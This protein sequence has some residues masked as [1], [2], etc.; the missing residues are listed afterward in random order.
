MSLRVVFFGTPEMA[1]AALTAVVRAGHRVLAGVCQPDRPA[2]RGRKLKPPQVK[3]ECGLLGVP[4]LQPE[5]I[6][7]SGFK[8]ELATLKPDVLVVVAYG[9]ILDREILDIPRIMPVNLHF[10]LLPQLRGA[11]PHNWALIQGLAETGVTTIRMVS[12][13]DAGPILLQRRTLIEPRETAD[14][15]L[16]RLTELGAEVLVETLQGLEKGSIDPVDQDEGR[17]T[18]APMLDSRT[19]RLDPS[20]P[21]ARVFD[22]AR[23]VVP[24]PGPTLAYGDKRLKVFDLDWDREPAEADPGTVVEIGPKGYRI[25]CN[26]GHLVVGRV[27]HPGKKPIPAAQAAHGSGPRVGERLS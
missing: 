8:E 10:S 25:A 3:E 17:V 24:W 20:L 13:L 18:L 1:R 26:G 11:A 9:R 15:L 4:V 23:G 2:G 19:G 12:K 14:R 22:L 21:S 5:S 27:Q 16:G 6:K 7:D